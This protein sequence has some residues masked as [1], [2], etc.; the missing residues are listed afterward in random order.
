[1]SC[2]SIL[3][4]VCKCH[5]FWHIQPLSQHFLVFPF[6]YFVGK[7]TQ[8]AT[9]TVIGRPILLA[10]ED[11]DGS[12]SFLEKA[13]RFIERQGIFCFLYL[14]ILGLSDYLCCKICTECF[15]W[16]S[17]FSWKENL[18]VARL[19]VLWNLSKHIIGVI[20]QLF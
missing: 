1:M 6:L 9:S 13:L 4:C 19:H 12:P 18:E 11:I 8:P 7:D 3:V 15:N 20:I 5:V 14:F 2:L 16:A 17:V 10:L